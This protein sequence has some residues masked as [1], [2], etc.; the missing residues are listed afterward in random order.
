MN[1]VI[2]HWKLAAIGG[3]EAARYNLGVVT[4]NN[5]LSMR[6]FIIAARSGYDIALKKVGE[7]YKAGHVTKDEYANALRA[8]LWMR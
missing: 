8:C 7:G 5:E 6:H 2:H 4:C 1:K 3:H